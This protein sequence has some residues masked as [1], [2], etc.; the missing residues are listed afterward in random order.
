METGFVATL[1]GPITGVALGHP[2]SSWP[3]A[4][5]GELT[6]ARSCVLVLMGDVAWS[7]TRAKYSVTMVRSRSAFTRRLVAGSKDASV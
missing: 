3:G 5:T 4:T 7:F 6:Q 2:G 1:K